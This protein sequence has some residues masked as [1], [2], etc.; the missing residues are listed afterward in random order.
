MKAGSSFSLISLRTFHHHHN[1]SSAIRLMSTTVTRTATDAR[2]R[3]SPAVQAAKFDPDGDF[4]NNARLPLLLYSQVLSLTDA[5]PTELASAFE[6]VLDR[7]GWGWGWRDGIYPYHHYHSTQHEFLGVYSGSCKVQLG[8]PNGVVF[9]VAAGDSILIP[10]GVSHKNVGQSDDFFCV[11]AY[12]PGAEADMNYG[13][14]DERPRVDVN[15]A[16]VPLPQRDPLYGDD[17]PLKSNWS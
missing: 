11:G 12:P 8:G 2:L 5:E 10:A 6:S 13:K 15:I 14:P 1:H 3:A 7:N 4:P 16:K 17:G 9:E